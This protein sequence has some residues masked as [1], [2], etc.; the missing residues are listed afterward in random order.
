[1]SQI[2]GNNE[3]NTEMTNIVDKETKLAHNG[4]ETEFADMKI[5]TSSTEKENESLETQKPKKWKKREK[6]EKKV[7]QPMDKAKKKKLRRRILAGAAIV[8]IAVFLIR[9]S[10]VAKNTNPVVY[11]ME[12][13]VEDVEQT[14]RT[15][16]TVK[17]M[18]SKSYFASVA[19]PVSEVM[20]SAGDKVKKGD[21]LLKYDETALTQTRQEAEL[22]L[23]SNEGNY[24]SSIYKNNQYIADLSEANTNLDVLDQQI[25]DN[26]N[27]LKELQKKIEDKKAWYANQGALLQ[28]SLLEWEKTIQ[29]EKQALDE[30][31]AEDAQ[32]D[33]NDKEKREKEEK[34]DAAKAQID[35]DEETYL[36]LQ[37]QVQ[38]NAYEQQNNQEIRDLERQ[39]ADVEALIADYKEYRAEMVS[40]KTSSENGVLDAGSKDKLE[41]DTALQKLENGEILTAVDAAEDGVLADFAGVVTEVEIVEG[42][43]PAENSKLLVLES[44]ENVLVRVNVSKYD[45]EKLA[46]GQRTEVDIAGRTYEGEVAKIDGMATVNSNGSA[47]VGVDIT[48]DNPDD[49]IFLGVEAKVTVH[50]ALA[51]GVVAIPME[52]IN[53]D[54]EGDFVYVEENGIVAK[55]RVTVGISSE[56]VCEI[57]EGLAAGEKVILSNGEELE[58]G[59]PVTAVSQ[60]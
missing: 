23:A 27:Y 29:D 14:L 26:E 46:V 25:A 30:R 60:E 56:S 28:V 21:V 54:R 47:V 9:N 37:Q 42:A 24:D 16:G 31:N 13:A 52:L 10:I 53:S 51:E 33:M 38:Y 11:T 36:E 44:M 17:S 41:A 3:E 59:M 49:G 2:T 32:R 58:E 20:V 40:Q 43:T 39:A 7:K 6:K 22:K 35:S 4:T 18:E 12:A 1:M 34:D 50:T 57:R 8:L 55:R 15:G 45:L 48:I 5:E 19:V